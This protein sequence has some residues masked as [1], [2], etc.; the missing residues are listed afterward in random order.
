MRKRRG[1][2]K[3]TQAEDLIEVSAKG[4]D[5]RQ[6]LLALL[7]DGEE[8]SQ[9]RAYYPVPPLSPLA[10]VVDAF[11]LHSN[12]PLELPAFSFLHFAAAELLRRRCCATLNGQKIEPDL[13]T[14]VLAPQG[15]LKSLSADW[16]GE[17][18]TEAIRAGVG[19]DPIRYFGNPAGPKQF[20][21]E[22]E[23]ANRSL[24]IK[25][26]F[27]SF[28]QNLETQTYMSP[29]KDIILEMAN[30]RR[31]C[32]G[33]IAVESPA[34]VIYGLAVSE[35][36]AAQVPSDALLDG[37]ASRFGYVVTR[38][39]ADKTAADHPFYAKDQLV[40]A[41]S[42]AWRKV[43]SQ[44]IRMD[45]SLGSEAEAA[46]NQTFRDYWYAGEKADVQIPEG[47]FRRI[48]FRGIKYALVYH[49]VLGHA[50]N[51]EI[52]A[53][54]MSWAA[55]V[56]D[57]NIRDARWLLRE[58]GLSDL[59]KLVA[60]VRDYLSR[61]PE[62]TPREVAQNVWGVRSVAHAREL[63]ALAQYSTC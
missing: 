12:I 54:A 6:M 44:N 14:V 21:S 1:R 3:N 31:I 9:M 13:W 40:T 15:C 46:F 16:M 53:D 56:C 45:Y 51:S 47:F 59:G 38:K 20:L 2:T 48:M 22:L 23:S 63:V 42:D 10:Q 4:D 34:L 18:V 17:A 29:M 58:R 50:E 5:Q 32:R 7:S 55:R 60:K 28:L 39:R 52:T 35:R 36:F 26:E 41:A 19:T 25:D 62:V 24:W 11:R 49:I 30:N 61:V 37:F 57:L 8:L 43:F 27:G 33:E